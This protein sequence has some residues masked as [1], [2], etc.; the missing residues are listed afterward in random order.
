MKITFNAPVVLGFTVAAAAVMLLSETIFP[1][2]NTIYF[3]STGYFDWGRVADYF[4]LF[5]HILGHQNWAHLMGNFSIIL[6]IGPI[7]EEKYGSKKLLLMILNSST[8]GR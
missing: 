5:S 8:I 3:A 4:R 7:L 6:L 2:L 1:G